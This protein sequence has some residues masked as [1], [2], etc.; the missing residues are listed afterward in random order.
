MSF[1]VTWVPAAEAELTDLWLAAPD[2][3]EV[4]IAADQI[5]SQLKSNPA[6]VGESRPSERRILIVPPLVVIYRVKVEDRIVQVLNVR[7]LN[8]TE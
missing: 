4:R 5:D 1:T 3:S 8:P 6:D 7:S 2:R